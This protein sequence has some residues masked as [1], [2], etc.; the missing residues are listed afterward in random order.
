M[1]EKQR[2][3]YTEGIILQAREE[4]YKDYVCT[5]QCLTNCPVPS[6]LCFWDDPLIGMFDGIKYPEFFGWRL[7]HLMED[8]KKQLIEIGSD[9]MI[10][11]PDCL[12]EFYPES[13]GNVYRCNR[14]H[15]TNVI[16]SEDWI[17]CQYCGYNEPRIDYPE[18]RKVEGQI[19][20]ATYPLSGK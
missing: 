11:T 8:Q 7:E 5:F 18:W 2:I 9:L 6:E 12:D 3:V 14:C 17:I 16:F 1:N 13:T 19:K 10:L 15:S 20:P 4:E